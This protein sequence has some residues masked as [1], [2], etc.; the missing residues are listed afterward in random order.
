[1]LMLFPEEMFLRHIPPWQ[2]V[3]CFESLEYLSHTPDDPRV[4]YPSKCLAYI[5]KKK[6]R[7]RESLGRK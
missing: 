3:R 6:F 1:M 7:H 5:S 2:C 4:N